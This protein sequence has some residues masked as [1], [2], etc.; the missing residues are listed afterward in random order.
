MQE[1]IEGPIDEFLAGHDMARVETPAQYLACLMALNL[2]FLEA[3]SARGGPAPKRTQPER[4]VGL[5]KKR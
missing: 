4:F 1:E 2:A 5:L 3:P